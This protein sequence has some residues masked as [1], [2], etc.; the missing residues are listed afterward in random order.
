MKIE[1]FPDPRPQS[2]PVYKSTAAVSSSG[3]DVKS[4]KGNVFTDKADPKK[5]YKKPLIFTQSSRINNHPRG[6]SGSWLPVV[7]RRTVFPKGN[8]TLIKIRAESHLNYSQS[9][10]LM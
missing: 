10:K 7:Y 6:I 9:N 2:V 1:E 5:Y 8:T 3:G 4:D